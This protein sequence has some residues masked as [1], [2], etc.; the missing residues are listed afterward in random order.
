MQAD[1]YIQIKTTSIEM[2]GDRG[3]S[4]IDSDDDNILFENTETGER[5]LVCIFDDTKLNVN[6]IKDIITMLNEN[7]LKH[8][9]I[10]YND[11][12]TSTSK[13]IIETLQDYDIEIFS[14]DELKFNITKHRLVPKHIKI[15]GDEYTEL[16]KH[17]SKLPIMLKSEP[18]S[19][20]YHYKPS[21][22]I[23]IERSE[24]TIIYRVVR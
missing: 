1:K 5:V 16:K 22:I 21:D 9:I 15:I 23:R 4:V 2:M 17:A 7:D 20:Y 13:K 10:I 3:Y 14:M 24:G 18:I 6:N 19:R 12:I 11:V 8:G